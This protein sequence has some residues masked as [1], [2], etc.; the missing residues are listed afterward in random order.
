MKNKPTTHQIR[1]SIKLIFM[2]FLLFFSSINQAQETQR[3]PFYLPIHSSQLK[4]T[5]VK[6]N[7]ALLEHGFRFELR[8][9]DLWQQYQQD[10]RTG[11]I[12]V[13]F[14]PPHFTAWLVQQHKFTPLLKIESKL[15][16][17]IASKAHD[18]HIFEINDLIDKKIC[19]QNP[20]NLDYL[21]IKH[22]FRQNIQTAETHIV[23]SVFD[24]MTKTET[25]C[26]AFSISNHIIENQELSSVKY[27]RLA[28]SAELNNYAF[29]M[30][31]S[32]TEEFLAPLQQLLS[33][34]ETIEILAPMLK[35]TANDAALIEVKNGDYPS[36]YLTEL[37][38][39]WGK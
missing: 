6:F 4:D 31:P 2:P 19:T 12:G 16:Y 38:G 35:L 5:I 18:H 15:K 21:L 29:S 27:I 8:H 14:T 30:H 26:S 36:K 7:D 13:Y 1:F 32:L 9:S 37:E 10:V 28:Q 39:Y 34:K 25:P 20:L 33:K 3:I 11:R 23:K 22:A 17:I 24:E